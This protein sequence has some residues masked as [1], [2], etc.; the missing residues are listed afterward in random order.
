M[1]HGSSPVGDWSELVERLDRAGSFSRWQRQETALAAV[2]RLADLPSRT[3]R[4][5]DRADAD[6][7]V[8]SPRYGGP[9]RPEVEYR[10]ASAGTHGP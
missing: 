7:V 2:P 9:G 10:P 1:F 6:R 4:E 8:R 3:G 5:V